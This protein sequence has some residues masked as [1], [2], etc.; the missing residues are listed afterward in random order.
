MK[1]ARPALASRSGSTG[2]VGRPAAAAAARG[3]EL[4]VGDLQHVHQLVVGLLVGVDLAA[5]QRRRR[6]RR[7][8]RDLRVE[9]AWRSATARS[10]TARPWASPAATVY[11]DGPPKPSSVGSTRTSDDDRE[12]DAGRDQER[13]LAHALGELAPRDEADARSLHGLAEQLGQRRP[14]DREVRDR[15]AARAASRIAS[16]SPPSKTVRSGRVE[17]GRRHVDSGRPDDADRA[18]PARAAPRRCRRR[19]GGRP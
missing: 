6:G 10:A 7:R 2:L 12:R 5:A 15:P 19:P 18:R 17:H 3:V 4:L 8:D 14:L 13:A 1:K 9:L 11:F 16:G